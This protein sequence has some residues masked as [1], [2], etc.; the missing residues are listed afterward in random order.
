MHDNNLSN[1][2]DGN[3]KIT[4]DIIR[5]LPLLSNDCINKSIVPE[6]TPLAN[7]IEIGIDIKP[8]MMPIEMPETR[9]VFI[10]KSYFFDINPAESPII[11]LTIAKCI[12]K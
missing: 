7:N 4:A 3:V 8:L 2:A 12:F 1:T 11:A 6:V 5:L 10:L 9:A